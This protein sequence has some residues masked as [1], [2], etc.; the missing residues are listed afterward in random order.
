MLIHFLLYQIL[1]EIRYVIYS[2]INE[3]KQRHRRYTDQ[4]IKNLLKK[5]KL[6]VDISCTP[7]HA[8]IHG[9]ELADKVVKDRGAS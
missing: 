3:S 8:N 1:S 9:N 4:Y 6:V 7:G 2:Y 5:L